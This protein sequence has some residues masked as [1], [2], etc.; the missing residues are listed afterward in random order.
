MELTA[1]KNTYEMAAQ[2]RSWLEG[3][4]RYRWHA[5]TAAWVLG[6]A[7][8]A[9]VALIPDRYLASSRVYVDTQSILRPLL[10]GL[11]MQPNVTQIVEMMSRTLVSRPNLERVIDMAGVESKPGTPQAHEKT[12]ERLGRDLQIKGTGT[13]NLYTITYPDR[14]PERAKRVVQS[15]L[16]IFEGGLGDKRKDSDVARSFIEEQLKLYADRLTAAEDAVTAF[17]RKNIGL[18]PGQGENFYTR[19]GEMR[20]ALNQARLELAEAE[21]GRDALK[22][23]FSEEAPPSLIDDKALYE[24]VEAATPELDLRIAALQQKLDALK[25]TYTD[26]H[27][28]IVAIE[29]A[30]AQLKEQRA[31]ER[32]Q[33]QREARAKRPPASAT[34]DLVTQQLTISLAEYDASVA[35]LKERVR[36]YEKRMAE[37]AAAANAIPQVEAQYTQLTRDYEVT[38]KNYD[39]LASR[40]ESAQLTGDVQSNA[41]T[42]EFRVIDPP[43]VSTQPDWPNR[44]LLRSLVLLAA[45][46]MGI[47]FAFLMS[48]LRPTVDSE[49]SL[50]ELSGLTVFGTVSLAWTGEQRRRRKN[51]L[52]ALGLCALALFGVY[53]TLMGMPLTER[54]DHVEALFNR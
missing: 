23:R 36:E 45:I 40:R 43:Q 2:V 51:E 4:W 20:T 41:S 7:G 50:R 33:K 42:M 19:L 13:Q 12:L 3:T 26:R 9:L 1:S 54:I 16:T 38:K 17:K 53:A 46:A 49:R 25:V 11:A 24:P 31:R 34:K 18:M 21:Q 5:V 35:S 29:P 30:L 39:Q 48:R 44:P 22:R 37:L 10:A 27:P 8:W 47:A 15:L 14:D 32:E 28:D 6:L 52:V